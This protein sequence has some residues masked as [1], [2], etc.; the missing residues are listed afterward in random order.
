VDRHHDLG[1]KI[2][3]KT[4]P[5]PE[6]IQKLTR[7]IRFS[8]SL[9]RVFYNSFKRKDLD[10]VSIPQLI[11]DLFEEGGVCTEAAE[12]LLEKVTEH[13]VRAQ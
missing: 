11:V 10:I 5:C 8:N 6:A 7:T 13:A 1:R 9:A 2:A 4:P 3:R 12:K